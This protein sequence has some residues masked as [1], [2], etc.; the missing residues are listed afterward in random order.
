[1]NTQQ[2]ASYCDVTESIILY[3]ARR[4]GIGTKHKGRWSFTAEELDRVFGAGA[5]F[6]ARLRREN[7]QLR[8][9]GNKAV[10]LIKRLCMELGYDHMLDPDGVRQ[11]RQEIEALFT[12][13]ESR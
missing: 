6:V 9:A 11:L 1:M 10:Y 13:K 8:E 3:V 4:D 7:N 12:R 5:P 2:A